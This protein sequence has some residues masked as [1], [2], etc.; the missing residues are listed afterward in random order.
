MEDAVQ[1]VAAVS[2]KRSEGACSPDVDDVYMRVVAL[3][4]AAH[5][6]EPADLS[7]ALDEFTK[8]V[9]HDV[10]AAHVGIA[11]IDR[12]EQLETPSATGDYPRLLGLIQQRH[13]QGPALHAIQEGA[14]VRIDDLCSDG[15]WPDYARDALTETPI[16]SVLSF[17]M[18]LDKRPMGA[19]SLFSEQP[20][21][22]DTTAESVGNVYATHIALTWAVLRRSE[23]YRQAL[24]SRDIIGQA[25]GTLMERYNINADQAFDRLRRLSQD[26]NIPV[27]EIARRLLDVEYTG[28]SWR[29]KADE[30][31]GSE[32]RSTA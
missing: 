23:Q 7:A 9:A 14:L 32:K 18:V 13:H 30:L 20:G 27:A 1:K 25:K 21:A 8:S 28:K 22:F 16:R 15:R 2:I 3:S 6:R 10:P 31:E 12:H 26:F 5:E 4:R 11:V 29:R 19:L 17:P 24:A